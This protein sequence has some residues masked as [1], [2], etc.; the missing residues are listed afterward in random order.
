MDRRAI[1]SGRYGAMLRQMGVEED[2]YP[3]SWTDPDGDGDQLI[4]VETGGWTLRRMERGRVTE[5]TWFARSEPLL[6][7]LASEIAAIE[8]AR[9]QAEFGIP[10]EDPRRADFARRLELMGRIS[11]HWRQQMAQELARW[12]ARHP[13]RDQGPAPKRRRRWRAALGLAIVAGLALGAAAAHWPLAS[14]MIRQAE[15]DRTGERIQARV[16]ELHRV[17]GRFSDIY[18]L[19]YR[20]EV[21]GK[22]H[23][24]REAVD[25]VRWRAS[26]EGGEI[27]A[28]VDSRNPDISMIAGNDRAGRMLAIYL[29]IDAILALVIVMGLR[30]GPGQTAATAGEPGSPARPARS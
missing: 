3:L 19:G 15:L 2:R 18:L 30:G 1:F 13:Y 8:G 21:A 28:L 24:A 9:W 16:I 14:L 6:Y 11:D 23:E 25:W 4:C 12:L 5:E 20:F 27:T 7:R 22:V 17:D 10:G 29:A 26:Q